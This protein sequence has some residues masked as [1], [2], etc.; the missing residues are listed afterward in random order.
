MKAIGIIIA[1][2]CMLL[3]WWTASLPNAS[4]KL[5]GYIMV[6]Y[7]IGVVALVLLGRDKLLAWILIGTGV[8]LVVAY[9]LPM[10]FWEFVGLAERQAKQ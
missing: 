1:L 5:P 6:G 9:A 4:Q 3:G 10:S 8:L 2:V 7:G